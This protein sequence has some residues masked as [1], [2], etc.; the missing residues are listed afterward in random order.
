MYITLLYWRELTFYLYAVIQGVLKYRFNTVR[1]V[2]FISVYLVYCKKL[3]QI[4]NIVS[5]FR[6]T[7]NVFT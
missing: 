2:A 1:I 5:Q 6:Q 7:I 3:I 4:L